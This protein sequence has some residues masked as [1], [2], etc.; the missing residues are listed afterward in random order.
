[1]I[2]IKSFLTAAAFGFAFG[3]MNLPLPAPNALAGVF[4]VVGVFAGYKAWEFWG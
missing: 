4:G 2:E 1:M 3:A